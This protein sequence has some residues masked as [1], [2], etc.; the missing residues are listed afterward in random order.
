MSSPQPV[1]LII[2]YNLSRLADV[3][4]LR[5]HALARWGAQTYLIRANPQALDL[6]ISDLVFD[7]D[8][9]NADFVEQ[10]LHALGEHAQHITAG[11]VFSDNAVASGAALLERLGL[12]V[13]DA[14]L[15]LGAFD[16]FVYRTHEARFRQPMQNDGMW[17]PA[18]SE[19]RSVRDLRCFTQD[20][21]GCVVKPM[22]E[23][24]NRGVVRVN[25]GD[26]LHAAFDEVKPYVDRGVL[27]EEIIPYRREFSFDGL[28]SLS[29]IT[30]KVSA[31]GRYPVEV[32][33]VLPARLSNDERRT[34]MRAGAHVNAL[35]GQRNGP[36]HN[37]IKLS[38]DGS[39][40][41]VVEPN[42]RPGG[43]KIWT[44]ANWVY[45]FDFYHAWVD[46]VFGEP[47]PK[48]LPAPIAS[49]AT[50]MLGVA[51]DMRFA[52]Y[53]IEAGRHPL[54]Q[55]MFATRARH[56]LREHELLADEFSWMALEARALHRVPH[57][58][59]DFAAQ[60]CIVLKQ[61]R[62]DIRE[63]ISTLRQ[64]WL[65]ALALALEPRALEKVAS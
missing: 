63:V 61:E 7:V 1:L 47:A 28:G 35:I 31:E 62:E 19:V 52:P 49:A 4:H 40:A 34:L 23:G 11:I 9:L 30:E 41:A 64:E 54:E 48:N 36:F 24:N 59:A 50:V 22:C 37:E 33:Q 56:G 14:R 26:D 45:G 12:E 25:P 20:F 38:D 43:M 39:R 5:R 8:P 6:S 32:A 2:D 27:A 65:S 18:F 58:N 44:L 46:S 57:D 3:F 51:E 60:V 55:A 53:Y 29:F 13:D 42:R 16:K 15:A 10:A 21:S 17:L